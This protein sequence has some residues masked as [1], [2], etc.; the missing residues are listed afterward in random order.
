M[1]IHLRRHAA[2]LALTTVLSPALAAQGDTTVAPGARYEAGGLQRR[3]LGEGYREAWTTPIRVP[4]LSLDT[5]AGGLTPTERGGGNQTS[6]LRFRGADGREYAFRSVDKDPVRTLGED[7]QGTLVGGVLRDLVSAQLPAGQLAMDVLEDALGV[8]HAPRRLYVMPDD[9]RLGEFRAEFAG[10]LGYFEER[11]DEGGSGVRGLEHAVE[12]EGTEDFLTGLSSDGRNRLD[13]RNYLA[14]R[15]LDLLVGDWDRHDDQFRWAAFDEGGLRVWR[16]IPRD[17]DYVFVDYGGLGPRLAR[18]AYPKAVGFGPDP[19]ADLFGLIQNAQELDRRL[20]TGV[21]RAAWDSVTGWVQARLTDAVI[22]RAVARLPEEHP[23]ARERVARRLRERRGHLPAASARLYR[24]MAVEPEVHARNAADLARVERRPDGALE[25]LLQADEAAAPYFRR[26]YPPA[27]TR[28]VRI[29]LHDGD[30]QVRVHGEGPGRIGVRVVG[31]P[32]DDRFADASRHG[33]TRFY[34]HEGENRFAA[35]PG[36]RVDER[37]YRAPEWK[38]GRGSTP[39]RDWGRSSSPLAPVFTWR[40]RVGPLVGVGPRWTD[41]G[42]RREPVEDRGRLALLAAP[43]EQRFG[44]EYRGE[45]HFTGD[46]RRLEVDVRATG[47]VGT[48]FYG[49]GNQAPDRTESAERHFFERQLLV[50]PTWFF[51]LPGESWLAVGPTLEWRDPEPGPASV[52]RL[53]QARGAGEWGALGA[54][55]GL[56]IDRRDQDA[57][58]RHG[59]RLR[60]AA[61]AFPAVHELDGAFGAAEGAAST[62]LSAGSGPVLAL[63][64]GGRLAW[65]E[66][67]L[68]RAAYLGGGE[69]LRGFPGDRFAGDAAAFGGG[70]LRVPLLRA[71]LGV[72]GTVGALGLAEAGRVWVSGDSPGDWHTAAGGGLYFNFLDGSRTASL[73]AARGEVTRIYAHLGIPF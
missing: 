28:E 67:P 10:M 33:D 51:P 47:L 57:F 24:W 40:S 14:M 45:Y 41:Y 11:P 2:V 66:F 58:P 37:S 7:F 8:L 68:Q 38:R 54:R 30:D 50:Q 15:L 63:R 46:R 34:D 62:Y 60:L 26:V 35:R 3:L 44:L 48:S 29:H 69:S 32:G 55:A 4:F 65:G 22:D 43:L 36:T 70:E 72:R 23:G 1:R 21:D 20:L 12:V 6:S 53:Q 71:N 42:F 59:W 9:A 73:Y 18:G 52:A 25:V 27:E 56:E 19:S 13:E 49:F 64:G 61:D 39:P 31:G 16:P 17:R 5:V